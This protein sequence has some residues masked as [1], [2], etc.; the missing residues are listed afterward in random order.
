MLL[1][2]SPLSQTVTF[3]NPLPPSVT[4][5]MDGPMWRCGGAHSIVMPSNEVDAFCHT[6]G[7][8]RQGPSAE[9]FS[10]KAIVDIPYKER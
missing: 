5:F 6:E 9:L 8:W 1:T 2:P 7:H 3:S 10:E 4:Y